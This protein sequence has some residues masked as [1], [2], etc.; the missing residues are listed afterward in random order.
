MLIVWDTLFETGIS[1]IDKQHKR[2]VDIIN[3]VYDGF[4]NNGTI[5]NLSAILDDLAE[6]TKYHFK[7][8]EDYFDQ[9]KFSEA[10]AHKAE[11]QSFVSK[12]QEFL[13]KLKSRKT[14]VNYEIIN[15]LKEW[16]IHHILD[17]DQKYITLFK[18]NGL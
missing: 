4:A 7:T 1:E 18:Q 11:H 9:F 12:V 13:T 15:F 16:L 5:E 10:A 6:Y 8:E 14:V 2:L 17:S 3:R